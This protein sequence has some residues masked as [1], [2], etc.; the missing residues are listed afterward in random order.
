MHRAFT[1]IIAGIS[2]ALTALLAV[3]LVLSTTGT[4]ANPTVQSGTPSVVSY[5]GYLSDSGGPITGTV[6]LRFSIYDALTGGSP[7]WQ[8]TQTGV[9]VSNGYFSVLLGSSTSLDASVFSSTT[10]YLQIEVDT[11]NTGSSYTTLSPRQQFAAVPY[12]YQAEEVPWSGITGKPAGLGDSYANVIVVAKSGGDYTSVVD[13]LDSITS[14]SATN[15]YL[16]YVAPGEYTSTDLVD[17]PGYV[18]LKGAGPGITTLVSERT[19]G[20]PANTGAATAFLNDNARISNMTIVNKGSGGLA[21]A[22][23]STGGPTDYITPNAVIDNV[24]AIAYEPGTGGTGR[25]AILL[26]DSEATIVNSTLQAW[27]ASVSSTALAI[28]STS[29]STQAYIAN[30]KLYGGIEPGDSSF[31][32]T[33]EVQCIGDNSIPTSQGI[34][35]VQISSSPE[36]VD[37]YICG[38]DRAISANNTGGVSN[39]SGSVIEVAD[40]GG[41]TFLLEV[42][43]SGNNAINIATSRLKDANTNRIDGGATGRINCVVSYNGANNEV[44]T[45]CLN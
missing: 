19:A 40:E 39:I 45:N 21:Y 24:E 3:A 41:D 14:A 6:A 42:S 13:A 2:G 32:S 11:T 38:A 25:A 37:S 17:V 30:S 1:P 7:I 16:V 26:T 20:T 27:G 35:L 5:Q 4:W 43:L 8:E 18:H 9:T 28:N 22:I 29:G 15:T 44:Q 34:G 33:N 23:L 31:G 10:R 12:A 36:I